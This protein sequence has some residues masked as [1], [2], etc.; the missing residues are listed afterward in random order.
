VALVD[1]L[2]GGDDIFVTGNGGDGAQW[3]LWLQDAR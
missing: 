1:G 2:F 3:A